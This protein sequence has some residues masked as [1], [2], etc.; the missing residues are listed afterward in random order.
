MVSETI[1]DVFSA[2]SLEKQ[3]RKKFK[4]LAQMDANQKLYRP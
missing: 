2:Y 1:N 4:V 3:K